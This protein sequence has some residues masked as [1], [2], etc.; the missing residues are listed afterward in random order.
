MIKDELISA[1]P[2]LAKDLY[3]AFKAARDQYVA[4]LPSSTDEADAA[5]KR[6]AEMVGGDPL[7]YGIEPNRKAME[8]IIAAAQS[9][10][11]LPGKTAVEDVFVQGSAAW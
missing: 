10:H 4:G 8:A 5:M 6:T 2:S 3:D 11:I 1:N 9:Q 7:P